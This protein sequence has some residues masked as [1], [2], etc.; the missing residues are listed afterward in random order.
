MQP[1]LDTDNTTPW[2][3]LQ[4]TDADASAWLSTQRADDSSGQSVALPICPVAAVAESNRF[5]A[6]VDADNRPLRGDIDDWA[7]RGAINAGQAV[8][9]YLDQMISKGKGRD[10]VYNECDMLGN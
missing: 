5:K 1:S 2:C 3:V 6:P 10:L 8:F 7:A 4:P 9:V